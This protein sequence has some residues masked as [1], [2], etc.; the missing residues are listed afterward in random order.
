MD[1]TLS[2]GVVPYAA[3]AITATTAVRAKAEAG[4]TARR[5]SRL[6]FFAQYHTMPGI[7]TSATMARSHI[8]SPTGSDLPTLIGI[9]EKCSLVLPFPLL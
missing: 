6:F 7:A 1:C 4:R 5:R 3:S 9:F 8:R 2:V